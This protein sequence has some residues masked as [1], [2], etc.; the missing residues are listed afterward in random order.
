MKSTPSSTPCTSEPTRAPPGIAASGSGTA[1]SRCLVGGVRGGRRHPGPTGSCSSAIPT[2]SGSLVTSATSAS[3]A[4]AVRLVYDVRRHVASSDRP[5]GRTASRHPRLRAR[6]AHRA[7]PPARA[8]SMLIASRRLGSAISVSRFDDLALARRPAELDGVRIEQQPGERRPPAPE[9]AGPPHDGLVARPGQ[10]DVGEPELLAPLLGDVLVPVGV[11]AG[12]VPA[13]DVDRAPVAGRRVV[14]D[15][16]FVL[17]DPPGVP[18]VRAVD[19]RELEALAAV[20]RQHL[21]GLR[22]GFQPAA[23]VLVG[24]VVGGVGDASLQPARQRGHPEL[25]GHRFEVEELADVAEIGE[26]AITVGRGRAAGREALGVGHGLEDA[27]PHRAGGAGPPTGG[28]GRT[29]PPTPRRRP[30]RP[31]RPTSRGTR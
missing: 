20:D 5:N 15:G 9:R 7:P 16:R 11:E 30:W 31:V 19:D 25:F 8:R 14:E 24:G 12:A 10:R 26:L 2:S 21:H 1:R 23:A 3:W 18:E 13:A 17:R 28:R 22:V 27:T 6:P 4:S 29:R